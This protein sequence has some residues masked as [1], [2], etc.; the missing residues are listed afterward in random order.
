MYVDYVT[1]RDYLLPNP[2]FSIGTIPMILP[3]GDLC[4]KTHQSHVQLDNFY[5]EKNGD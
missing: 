4:L 1:S 5:L 3:D 2:P